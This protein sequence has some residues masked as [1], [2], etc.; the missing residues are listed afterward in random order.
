[1]YLML[2]FV[3]CF[4]VLFDYVAQMVTQDC[5]YHVENKSQT[6]LLYN[7]VLRS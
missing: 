7:L 1:M 6:Y 2:T 4:N 3:Y 5:D